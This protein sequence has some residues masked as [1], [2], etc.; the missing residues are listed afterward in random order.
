M[1][2][3]QRTPSSVERLCMSNSSI[4]V[5]MFTC[6][7]VHTQ[8]RAYVCVLEMCGWPGAEFASPSSY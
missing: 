7:S 3:K 6:V 2:G 8:A 1:L 5:C 4:S